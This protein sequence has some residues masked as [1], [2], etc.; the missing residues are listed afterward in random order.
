MVTVRIDP[1]IPG[2]TLTSDVENIVRRASEM[3]IKNIRFSVMDQYST[4]K[5]FMEELGYDYS[6][7]YDGKS[8][9]ARP[10]IL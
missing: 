3:G 5:K 2:V 1:I 9:H 10:E 7:Y 8:L 6:K 4:T